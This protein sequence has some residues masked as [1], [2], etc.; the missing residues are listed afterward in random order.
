VV[1]RILHLTSNQGRC[2][3]FAFKGFLLVHGQRLCLNASQADGMGFSIYSE[4]C[5][6]SWA[7]L[8]LFQILV[9]HVYFVSFSIF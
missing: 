6:L 9:V 4:A 8:M 7:S 3:I 5:R 2:Y 1:S